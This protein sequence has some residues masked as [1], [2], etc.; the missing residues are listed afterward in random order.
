[1]G[2]FENDPTTCEKRGLVDNGVIETG[3]YGTPGLY[4]TYS[5]L[6]RL[7]GERAL[8]CKNCVE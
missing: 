2:D 6:N 8:L 5:T 1:M 3:L 7:C 4:G